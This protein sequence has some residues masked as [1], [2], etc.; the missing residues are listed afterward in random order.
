L[1]CVAAR[2]ADLLQVQWTMCVFIL[3]TVD[4]EGRRVGR[5]LHTRR[6]VGVHLPVLVVETFELQF[7]IG[8]T[9]ERVVHG[10]LQLKHVVADG[11]IV[12][13]SERRQDNAIA[14]W[15]RQSQLFICGSF[16]ERLGKEELKE[17][18]R[19]AATYCAQYLV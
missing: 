10:W 3:A 2:L 7:E 6:P 8:P 4:F 11:E 16:T 12:L 5:H 13:E 19:E 18:S 15:E 14:D 1:N 17:Q 9:H